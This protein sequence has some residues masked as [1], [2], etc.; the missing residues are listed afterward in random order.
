MSFFTNLL[1]NEDENEDVQRI[2]TGITL[3][4]NSG[5]G[6][7]GDHLP[8]T[9]SNFGIDVSV[10]ELPQIA[11]GGSLP[12]IEDAAPKIGPEME[13]KLLG[14]AHEVDFTIGVCFLGGT[15]FPLYKMADIEDASPQSI[16]LLFQSDRLQMSGQPPAKATILSLVSYAM[17][18]TGSVLV[19]H[20]A[21]QIGFGAVAPEAAQISVTLL[22]DDITNHRHDYYG[23]FYR[24]IP[25][26]GMG[27]AE[28]SR[29]IA[30]R[31]RQEEVWFTPGWWAPHT[32]AEGTQTPADDA[33]QTPTVEATDGGAV[34]SPVMNEAELDIVSLVPERFDR[35]NG[36]GMQIRPIKADVEHAHVLGLVP[37]DTNWVEE[38]L[39]RQGIDWLQ[40][41]IEDDSTRIAAVW[42]SMCA[43]YGI[44]TPAQKFREF[45]QQYI[46]PRLR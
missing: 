29:T 24:T 22:H 6:A 9:L 23:M 7:V 25:A 12:R 20:R 41:Q 1:G 32:N 43:E 2:N 40:A 44:Q 27:Q 46:D 31:A 10:C 11:L 17:M 26:S 38:T 36:E 42:R 34:A 4:P 14:H 45:R 39:K 16:E 19:D 28:L 33:A 13:R 21:P 18:E 15:G 3:Y 30:R 8:E 37:L 5:A 35:I